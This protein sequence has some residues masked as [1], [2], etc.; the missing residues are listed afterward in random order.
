MIDKV[1]K[2]REEVVRLKSNLI[3]GACSS[4]I[5]MET[6]CKEEAY[7]EVLAILDTMQEEPVSEDL[8][9]VSKE[10][11]APQLDKSYANYGEDKMMELTRFDGYDM[12]DAVEFGAKWKEQQMMAKTIDAHCFGFQDATALFTFRLPAGSYLVGSKVKVIVIKKD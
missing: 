12:L 9:K 6:R 3:Y 10:W 7:N 1:Q 8:E 4:Q 11:L 5:A 2:I